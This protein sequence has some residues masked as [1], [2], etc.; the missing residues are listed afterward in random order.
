MYGDVPLLKLG[1]HIQHFG[2]NLSARSTE[3]AI[4]RINPTGALQNCK[5]LRC[6]TRLND[7]RP[8]TF[9]KPQDQRQDRIGQQPHLMGL[10]LSDSHPT[11]RSLNLGM[12]RHGKAYRLCERE[13][14]LVGHRNVQR[15]ALR[16][17]QDGIIQPGGNC[18]LQFGLNRDGWCLTAAEERQCKAAHAQQDTTGS[19]SKCSQGNPH[20]KINVEQQTGRTPSRER[21]LYAA[22]I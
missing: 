1:N 19:E 21:R 3:S 22:L 5:Q 8:A 14:V 18:G 12:C 10:G 7:G 9:G 6:Q 13:N 17:E 20:L 15:P 4:R 16:V 2:H 11:E